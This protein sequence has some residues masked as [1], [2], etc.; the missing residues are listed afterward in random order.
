MLQRKILIPKEIDR[1]QWIEQ[2]K[3]LAE[4]RRSIY[5]KCWNRIIPAVAMMN[6]QAS[7]LCKMIDMKQLYSYNPKAD[8]KWKFIAPDFKPIEDVW[9]ANRWF[10]DECKYVNDLQSGEYP[11]RCKLCRCCYEDSSGYLK[12]H[13]ALKCNGKKHFV[14][15]DPN[16]IINQ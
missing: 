15:F 10:D 13:N 8:N 11:E 6:Q 3:C 2:I 5:V 14:K 4:C 12:C 16:K 1:I 9:E 7:V